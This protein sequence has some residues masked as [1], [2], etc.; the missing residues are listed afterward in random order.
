M[1]VGFFIL[2]LTF[3]FSKDFE[4]WGNDFI[5]QAGCEIANPHSGNTSRDNG[6]QNAKVERIDTTEG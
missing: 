4:W 3:H 6:R 2:N 5:S 1:Q